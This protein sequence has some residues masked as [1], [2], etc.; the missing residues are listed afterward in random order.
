M[1]SVQNRPLQLSGNKIWVAALV[2]LCLASCTTKKSTVLRSPSSGQGEQQTAVTK[3]AVD[4]DKIVAKVGDI[5]DV[6]GHAVKNNR[7]AL[8]LPFEL[9]G[10][11]GTITKED[12][13]RSSL[14][15]DF[16]QGFQLGLDKIAKEGALF[17]L[18]VID[19]R[20]NV[21]YNAT[22]GTSANVKDAVLVVGPVYPRE[23]KSFGQTFANKN[24]LQV[25]PLAATMASEFSL[26]N[27]V[28]IT[29]SI[30]THSETLAKYVADQYYTGDQILVY[31][32]GDDESKQFLVNFV[33]EISKAN[34]QAKVKTVMS[35]NELNNSLVLTGTNH[36]ISGTANKNLV[37]GLLDAMDERFLNPGNQ[38]KLYGHPNMAKLSFENFENMDFY[39][40]T[41]TSSNLVNE[42]D[43]D[44]RKFI[45]NY[46]SAYKVDPSEFSYKGYD[47]ALYFGRLIHK[48]GVD[49]VSRMTQ[50]KFSGLNSDY[51]FE[52]YPKWGY[53]NRALGIMVYHNKKF[54]RK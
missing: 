9:S 49:Y 54:E 28:S 50:D 29:P 43:S 16:Y 40:L 6:N 27:L 48:Y 20:D 45:G 21:A 5:Q 13:E 51:K 18:Q 34:A 24:V 19:S 46:K 47:A 4:K 2:A 33:S 35:V 8:L 26:P 30:R 32:A 37:K 44:T 25:S 39:G 15:L 52:F 41:I 10:I 11:A 3:P 23:I 7:I 12:V 1:I 42:S 17:D 22:L 14:A 53:A 38:F 31:D 36:V